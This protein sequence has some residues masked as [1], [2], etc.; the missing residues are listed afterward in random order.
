MVS[1]RHS[2]SYMSSG[3]RTV[4]VHEW[5]PA[6]LIAFASAK[7]ELG[8]ALPAGA[9]IEHAGST[10]VPGLP[11]KPTIDIVVVTTRLDVVREDPAC[12]IARGYQ[13]RPWVFEHD[14]DHV[15]CTRDTHGRR[16]EHLHVLSPRSSLPQSNRSFRDY[17]V[18]HPGEARRYAHA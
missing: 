11:A 17:L 8:A 6:W 3:P 9:T 16:T 1:L 10:S 14:P 13:F 4:E 18:S 15:F 12:L 2:L 5:T 7:A